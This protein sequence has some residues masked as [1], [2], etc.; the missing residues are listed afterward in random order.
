MY[1]GLELSSRFLWVR[2]KKV[3]AF[4][5]HIITN[6]AGVESVGSLFHFLF[7]LWNGP[8]RMADL[9]EDVIAI[10]V[11]SKELDTIR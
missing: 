5:C 4:L 11:G 2:G 6:G 7:W 3:S 8:Q 1:R 9:S 10:S